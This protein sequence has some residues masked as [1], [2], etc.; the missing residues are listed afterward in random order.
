MSLFKK[1][2]SLSM[3]LIIISILLLDTTK[4]I[5]LHTS[6]QFFSRKEINAAVMLFSFEDPYISLVHKSLEEIQN[7][8]SNNIK[9]TFYDGKKN[10]AIQNEQIDSALNDNYDLLLVDLVDLSEDT[11]DSVINHVKE[12]GYPII[13]FNTVPFS[14]QSI[15]SYNKALVISTYADQ[16]GILQG[17]LVINSWNSNKKTMDKNNDNVL[18]YIILK[19]PPSTVAAARSL[20]SIKTINDAG[21][22]TQQLTSVT[23]NWDQN[24]AKNS[25][26]SLFLKYGTKIEAIISNNDAMAIGAIEALQE[27]GYN[28][29]DKSKYIPVFGIDG[30][31]EAKDLVNKGIMAGTVIQDPNELAQ[32]LYTVGIN[33]VDNRNPLENT[34]YKFDETGITI[35]M[36]YYEYTLK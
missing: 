36:P 13:L 1:V 26:E 35:N 9:Y 4:R 21:I 30:I 16:S 34:N 23:A 20:Y 18:Q 15:K 3:I 12:K 17:N 11:V 2:L 27:Y 24:F 25:I 31:Q 29:D 6:V 7:K 8:Y 14:T 22:K 28:K 32:A 19:G 5:A 33:L 10:Q